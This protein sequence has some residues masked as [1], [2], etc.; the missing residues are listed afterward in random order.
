MVG[1]LSALSYNNARAEI[2]VP[3]NSRTDKRCR[4]NQQRGWGPSLIVAALCRYRFAMS[5][6]PCAWVDGGRIEMGPVAQT[7]HAASWRGK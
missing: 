6:D 7:L 4:Y 1:Q 2:A 5:I 3:N